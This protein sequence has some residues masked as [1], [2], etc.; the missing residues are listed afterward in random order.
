M[1][2]DKHVDNEKIIKIYE[3]AK[4]YGKTHFFKQE[5]QDE[6]PSWVAIQLS[7][8][9]YPDLKFLAVDYLREKYGRKGTGRYDLSQKLFNSS[10]IDENRVEQRTEEV[11]SGTVSGESPDFSDNFKNLTVYETT[12]ARRY[13]IDDKTMKEIG[14]QIGITESRVCQ[15]IADVKKKLLFQKYIDK[16]YKIN[17]LELHMN[18]DLKKYEVTDEDMQLTKPENYSVK[19]TIDILHNAMDTIVK[20]DVNAENVIA[21]CNCASKITD[22]LKVNLDFEKFKYQ[23]KKS[24]S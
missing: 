21:A 15:K 11:Y 3:R 20:K 1:L 23:V 10:E 13:F 14:K 9:R 6:F 2:K 19:K 7:R 8:G 16:E 17:E 4:R 12:I 5:D 22:I 24:N 18:Q